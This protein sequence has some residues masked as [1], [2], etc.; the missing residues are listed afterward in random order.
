MIRVRIQYVLQSNDQRPGGG[1]VSKTI[2]LILEKA[3]YLVVWK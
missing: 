1:F 3:I 2:F